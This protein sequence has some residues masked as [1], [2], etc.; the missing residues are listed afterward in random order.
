MA[1]TRRA[2]TLLAVL[3]LVAVVGLTFC[4][5]CDA[6]SSSKTAIEAAEVSVA[7]RCVQ[8]LW[9]HLS[10]HARKCAYW[11]QYITKV[12]KTYLQRQVWLLPLLITMM[13]PHRCVIAPLAFESPLTFLDRRTCMQADPVAAFEEWATAHGRT[14]LADPVVRSAP[15]K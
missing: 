2:A 4:S 9:Y 5:T 7:I 14:Y 1:S 13:A 6:V 8:Q 10:L 11:F 3:A 15:P 12:M